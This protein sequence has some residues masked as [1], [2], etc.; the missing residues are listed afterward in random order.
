MHSPTSRSTY[1]GCHPLLTAQLRSIF[2]KLLLPLSVGPK[3]ITHGPAPGPAA[4]DSAPA[5]AGEA[6]AVAVAAS[7]A[8]SLL[9]LRMVWTLRYAGLGVSLASYL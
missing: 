1:V 4:A 9:A 5:V 6:L 2:A 8:A 7:R 3:M